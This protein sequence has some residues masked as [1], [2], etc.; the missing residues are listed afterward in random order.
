MR[1]KKPILLFCADAELLS[2]LAFV[3]RLHPYKVTAVS[4]A[5][6]AV[7]IISRNDVVCG[8]LIHTQQGD[9]AG[10]VVPRILE[11][12]ARMHLLLVDYAGDLAP[13]RDADIVLYGRNAT[14]AHILASL[15]VLCARKRGPQPRSAA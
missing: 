8:V 9:L 10:R 11:C 15:K 7:R 4:D 5:H 2:S 1:P 6:V 12:A 13:V 14:T 3:L